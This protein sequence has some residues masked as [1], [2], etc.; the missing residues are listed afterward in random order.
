MKL[1]KWYYVSLDPKNREVKWEPSV[2]IYSHASI[3]LFYY[4]NP[5]EK[6]YCIFE[7]MMYVGMNLN[8]SLK[9]IWKAK[10]EVTLIFY[11]FLTFQ[12]IVIRHIYN[13]EEKKLVNDLYTIEIY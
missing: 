9:I 8:L 10:T 12:Y 2:E 6:S 11:W 1:F 7:I 3:I 4:T 13:Y 5:K